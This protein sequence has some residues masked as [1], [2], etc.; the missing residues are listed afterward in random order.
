VDSEGESYRQ[1]RGGRDL[2]VR[3]VSE[4][5]KGERINALIARGTME[6]EK[7]SP[8]GGSQGAR[9]VSS[10]FR[11]SCAGNSKINPVAVRIAW[12]SDNRFR[13]ADSRQ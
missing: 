6:N 10:P 2:V 9:Q 13:S 7:N 8:E 11:L 1:L 12:I 5:E 3:W 4:D